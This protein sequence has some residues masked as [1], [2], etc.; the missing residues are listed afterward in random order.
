M[1][2]TRPRRTRDRARQRW[3]AG[4]RQRRFARFMGVVAVCGTPAKPTVIALQQVG[5]AGETS[6]HPA[7]PPSGISQTGSSTTALAA[8]HGSTP[9]R[10]GRSCILS[11]AR[12]GPRILGL[13]AP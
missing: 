9:L 6:P 13:L 5:K 8:R 12:E 10:A 11:S 7:A 3:Y 2:A 1:D 4:Q